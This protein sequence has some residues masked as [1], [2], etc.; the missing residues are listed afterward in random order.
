MPRLRQEKISSLIKETAGKYL[1]KE[2]IPAK[3]CK[4]NILT[5]VSSVDISPDLKQSR[6]FITVFPENNEN[7]II[8]QIN[9]KEFRQFAKKELCLKFLPMF[10]FQIDEREKKRRKIEE[11]LQAK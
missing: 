4:Q 9:A 11:L 2:I 7:E 8:K 5:T 10:Q 6:I 3:P 1:R